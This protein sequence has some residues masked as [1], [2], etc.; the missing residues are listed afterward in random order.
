MPG[1]RK[2]TSNLHEIFHL[3]C[4]KTLGSCLEKSSDFKHCF[5]LEVEAAVERGQRV[6]SFRFDTSRNYYLSSDHDTLS[7]ACN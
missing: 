6:K 5:A 1:R 2:F 3:I 4:V 7:V